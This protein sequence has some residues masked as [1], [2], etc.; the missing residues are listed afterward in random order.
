MTAPK[1]ATSRPAALTGRVGQGGDNRVHDVALVQALL[2]TKRAKGGRPYLRGDHVTGKYDRATAEAL[3]RYRMDQRDANIRQPLARVGPMLNRLA[4]GQSLAVLEGTATPYKLATLAEPGA[5]EGPIAA[6]LSAQRKVALKGMMKAFI[7]D[8]GIALDVE[9]K[10]ASE[11]LPPRSIPINLFDS[12]PLVAHFTPRNLWVHNGRTLSSVPSNTQFR[13]HAKVLYEAVAADIKARCIETFG[14]KN[15]VDVKIQNGLKNDLACVVRTDLEGVEALA[16]FILVEFRRNGLRLAAR[17]LDHY[18]GAG[19]QAIDLSRDEA[20]E[21]DLIK[22]AAQ[23]NVEPFKE[24]N[25]ISPEQSTPGFL[26]V[27]EIA[28]NPEARFTN[29]E[30]HW[31]VDLNST[32][33]GLKRFDKAAKTDRTDTASVFLATGESSVTST[34]DFLLRRQGDRVLVTGTI[35]HLWTDPGYDFNPGQIFHP[36]SQVLEKHGKARP[37][38]WKAEWRD[39]VEGLLQIENVFTPNATRRWIDFD[40]HPG[41]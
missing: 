12:R 37:F 30:D 41:P 6:L 28:K 38:P 40:V 2:G 25:F 8:W 11:N 36:E 24:R 10:A 13:A 20:F 19:R 1:L 33:A 9:I 5:I 22:N 4:Q 31:K 18:L 21:F 14:I 3:M 26:A 15:P 35:T 7:Q 32:I 17:F 16:A 29:F 39:E 27:E 34:G 23:E